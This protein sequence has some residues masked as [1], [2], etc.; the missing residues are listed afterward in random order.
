MEKLQELSDFLGNQIEKLNEI[1]THDYSEEKLSA[2]CGYPEIENTGLCSE[3]K[4]HSE[5]YTEQEL[6]NLYN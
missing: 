6:H 2:C 1:R 4:D 5:F 3:C